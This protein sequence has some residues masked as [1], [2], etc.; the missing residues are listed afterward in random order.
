MNLQQ[1]LT[2]W[3]KLQDEDMFTGW[4]ML[5]FLMKEVVSGTKKSNLT[6][7]MGPVGEWELKTEDFVLFPNNM[8]KQLEK[9][10][11][12]IQEYFKNIDAQVN[13]SPRSPLVGRKAL[14]KWLGKIGLK[15]WVVDLMDHL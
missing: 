5:V 2:A 1:K 8:L 9:N 15:N 11:K 4:H 13:M 10:E 12:Q 3:Q 6:L 14:E 7:T